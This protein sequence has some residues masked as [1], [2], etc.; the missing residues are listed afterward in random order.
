MKVFAFIGPSGSGKSHRATW[1]AREKGA[2]FIVDDGLLI[3]GNRVVAGISAKREKTRISSIKRAIFKDVV[4]TN[5][6]KTAIRRYNPN[7]ILILGTSDGMVEEI[8]KRLP[9]L[10]S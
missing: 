8:S 2:E 1:V 5:D 3:L 6:V 10:K 7:G 9:F 4:H